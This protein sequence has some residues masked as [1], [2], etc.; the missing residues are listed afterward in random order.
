MVLSPSTLR[1]V[2]DQPQQLSLA[3]SPSSP[4]SPAGGGAYYPGKEEDDDIYIL[5]VLR[6]RG[7]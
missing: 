1:F 4:S 6:E 5:G 3:T 7:S 2:S